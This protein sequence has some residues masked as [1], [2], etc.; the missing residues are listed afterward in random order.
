MVSYIQYY[1]LC[2]NGYVASHILANYKVLM[3][4][5][6]NFIDILLITLPLILFIS[7][8]N[9]SLSQLPVATLLYKVLHI[10]ID[11]MIK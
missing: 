11:H 1:G 6:S 9:I 10:Y 4:L 2:I 5:S 8:S 7:Y 3:F